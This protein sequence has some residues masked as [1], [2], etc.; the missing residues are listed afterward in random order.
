MYQVPFYVVDSFTDTPFAGNPAGV[1]LDPDARLSPDHM[2][3]LCAEVSLESAFVTPGSSD[4]DFRLR[5]FT[6]TASIPFCGHDTVAAL[7][8]LADRGDIAL[9]NVPILT[10]VGRLVTTVAR[11]TDARTYVTLHQNPVQFGPVVDPQEVALALGLPPALLHPALP[12]QIASTGTP[13]IFVP[14]VSRGAVNTIDANRQAAPIAALTRKY[15][16]L[17]V[18]VFTPEIE[19]NGTSSCWSR[20]FC[21]LVGLNEDPVTGS[22]SGALAGY[23]VRFG[24]IPVGTEILNRQGFGGG[25]GGTAYLTVTHDDTLL[26]PSVRGTATI[27]ACGTFS[28]TV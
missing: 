1:F 23:L 26:R 4:A 2:M 19:P 24:L 20:G 6:G 5:Y 28:L 11:G 25:R 14:V 9:G 12:V 15:A 13:E 7:S 10:D 16:V 18:Y 22:A 3:R 8:V 21:P 27:V 17:G